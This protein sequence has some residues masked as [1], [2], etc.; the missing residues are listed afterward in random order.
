MIVIREATRDDARGI[1][2]VFVRSWQSAYRDI[3]PDDFLASL[4]IDK[5]E[6]RV[7]SG[8]DMLEG[9]PLAY[10]AEENSRIIGIIYLSAS[11]DED[12]L[13]AGEIQAI[14]LFEEYWGRGYGRKMMDHAINTLK[15]RG[16]P[17]I[18]IW[19]LEENH[20][21]RRFYEKNGF[22]FNGEKREREYGKPLVQ[23]KYVLEHNK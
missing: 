2:T 1:A 8:F 23:L 9:K 22:Y 13:L 12:K 15:D 14:Y 18:I 11:R 3:V 21:A 10:V 19:T 7:V 4:D 17:E 20:R 6:E 5:R 16:Y